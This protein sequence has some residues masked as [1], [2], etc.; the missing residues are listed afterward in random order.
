MQDVATACIFLAG[1]IEQSQN[2][3]QK[4]MTVVNHVTQSC[5]RACEEGEKRPRFLETGTNVYFVTKDKVIQAERLVL[6]ELGFCVHVKHSH[7]LAV[8]YCTLIG[9]DVIN[10]ECAN[11]AWSY[12][13][14]AHRTDVFVRYPAETVACA[15]VHLA[16][17]KLRIPFNDANAD[18]NT[19]GSAAAAYA[20]DWWSVFGATTEEIDAIAGAIT[21]MY[22]RPRRRY[23]DLR[24][25]LRGIKEAKEREKRIAETARREAKAKEWA[26]KK[27]LAQGNGNGSGS[28]ALGGAG[29]SAGSSSKTTP[30]SSPV[31]S[32]SIAGRAKAEA[33]A[34]VLAS[35]KAALGIK[36]TAVL[37]TFPST[38]SK[39]PSPLRSNRNSGV[40]GAGAGGGGGTAGAAE[41]ARALFAAK[42]NAIAAGGSSS[43]LLNNT[44]SSLSSSGETAAGGGGSSA[45]ISTSASGGG[46]AAS[47]KISTGAGASSTGSEIGR[48]KEQGSAKVRIVPITFSAKDA[49]R[50]RERDRDRTRDRDRDRDRRDDRDDRDRDR[51]RRDRDKRGDDDRDRGRRDYRDRSRERDRDRDRG[52]GGS[53]GGGGGRRRGG[54]GGGGGGGRRRRGR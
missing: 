44:S 30:R 34:K 36:S 45:S 29:G 2:R 21:A 6:K 28:P 46:A 1:K 7:M 11:L 18:Q 48:E 53:S 22:A 50:D 51:D 41:R 47:A 26:A 8:T 4:I 32:I 17:L 9:V 43:R 20:P 24:L 12:C 52:D 37:P 13:N 38:L 10:K 40:A 14:D 19:V 15:C 49:N 16:T 31:M 54:G 39:V 5:S 35:R 25:E 3:L 23:E 33:K 27:A 42:A